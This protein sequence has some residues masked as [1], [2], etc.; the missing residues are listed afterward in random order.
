M[1]KNV[2]IVGYN[3]GNGHPFSFS[4][5]INGYDPS[6]ITSAGWEVIR[7]YLDRRDLS[8]FG[9]GN[10]KVTH[11]WT[12]DPLTTKQLCKACFIPNAI[13]NIEDM[14]N[15]V[16]A[17][18]IARDDFECHKSLS[19]HF[20]E[21]DI[22]VFIDKP[23]SVKEE[24][25]KYFTP[26]LMHGKLM[27]CSSMRFARELDSYHSDPLIYGKLHL[28]RAAG[29]LSWVKYGIHLLEAI[30]PFYPSEP[31]SVLYHSSTHDSYIIRFKDHTTLLVNTLGNLKVP[32]LID[33][34]GEKTHSQT[35][36]ND[37]FSMFRRTLWHFFKSIE[38]KK[39]EISPA[40]TLTL[41]KV[42]MAGTQSKAGK[43]EVYLDEIVI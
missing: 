20:L 29:P 18:I 10:I 42:L 4:A 15:E 17:V 24:E 7:N 27:S 26:F 36:I 30:I 11:A 9:F 32:F 8:E 35:I 25:L 21:K 28:I 23:L 43:G 12:Q 37:N 33:F 16:D 19:A 38:T 13:T 1:V 5:I 41:M 34:F 31:L 14:C 6:L 22:P 39:P 3:K 40:S 2:G